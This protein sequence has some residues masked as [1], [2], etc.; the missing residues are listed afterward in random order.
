[1]RARQIGRPRKAA[2]SVAAVAVVAGAAAWLY[3]RWDGPPY[4]A[5]DP[6]VTARALDAQTQSVYDA[7]AVPHAKLDQRSEAG[8]SADL[9]EC[10]RPGISHW[11]DELNDSPPSAPGTVR[12]SE[13][14]ALAGLTVQQAGDA[15]RRAQK[16]LA[17][18]G[19][20]VASFE[21][22]PQE[23]TLLL[24]QPRADALPVADSVSVTFYPGGDLTVGAYSGLRTLP[25]GHT[26]GRSR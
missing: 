3:P 4:P 15:M 23:I 10:P 2:L 16:E 6:A 8:F 21:D 22:T 26:G 19:W 25:T 20:S 13:S 14:W 17:G 5:V 9:Y 18:R 24:K 1:M 7:L 12:V 11:L